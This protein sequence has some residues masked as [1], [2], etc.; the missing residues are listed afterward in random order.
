MGCLGFGPPLD[1]KIDYPSGREGRERERD[2][3]VRMGRKAR[4]EG[5]HAS[6]SA[7]Q[8]A[9]V[10][11]NH[12][13]TQGTDCRICVIIRFDKPNSILNCSFIW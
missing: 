12:H 11:G 1:S 4:G 9:V 7:Y 3:D 8:A 2:K 13:T 6:K 10:P 5:R